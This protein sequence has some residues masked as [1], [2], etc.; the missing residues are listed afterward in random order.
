[1]SQNNHVVAF[2]FYGHKV[3]LDKDGHAHCETCSVPLIIVEALRFMAAHY[4][5]SLTLD[6]SEIKRDV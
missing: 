5:R 2:E 1:M 3:Q 4:I 6:G